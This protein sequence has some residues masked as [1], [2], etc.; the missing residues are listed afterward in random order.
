[1]RTSPSF[2]RI[3]SFQVCNK[4]AQMDTGDMLKNRQI[5]E[6]LANYLHQNFYSHIDEN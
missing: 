5:L 1:M 2:L 3:G 6:P 4:S